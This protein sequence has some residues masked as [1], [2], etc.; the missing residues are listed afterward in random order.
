MNFW[1]TIEH[2]LSYK[3]RESLPEDMRAR[4]KKTAEAAFVLD[5]EMSAI[6][7]QIL[8]AQ[9][10]F[11]DDSNIVSRTLSIIQQLYFYHLVHEAIEAQRRF[12]DCWERNDMEGLKVLLDDVKGL[13]NNARKGENPDEQL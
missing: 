3:Y 8:E 12:N 10:A 13:L 9:K 7:L 6:R 11:E 1:A 5:N 4:L 2:S